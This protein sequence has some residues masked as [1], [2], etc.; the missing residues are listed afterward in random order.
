M[1]DRIEQLTRAIGDVNEVVAAIAIAATLEQDAALQRKMRSYAECPDGEALNLSLPVGSAALQLRPDGTIQPIRTHDVQA[2]VGFDDLVVRNLDLQISIELARPKI[3]ESVKRA[4]LPFI[5]P[6]RLPLREEYTRLNRW[7]ALIEKP[8]Y[9]FCAR[10]VGELDSWR[11]S[12]LA[13][14]NQGTLGA[15]TIIGKYSAL[16]H[17][18]AHLTLLCSSQEATP[19]LSDMAKSFTWKTWTPSFTL[20]RERTVWL[21]AAAARSAIAFGA[22]V[23]D[24]YVDVLGRATHVVQLFDALF[25][26]TAIGLAD[27]DVRDLVAREIAAKRRDSSAQPMTGA[28]FAE[29]AYLS[30]TVCLARSDTARLSHEELLD[31]LSWRPET[32]RGIA[33]RK[34]FRIDPTDIDDSGQMIGFRALPYLVKTGAPLHYPLHRHRPSSLLPTQNEIPELLSRAWGARNYE[35]RTVH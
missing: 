33:T 1:A 9:R 27:D 12:A 32:H 16:V 21:A 35:N 23:I 6:G 29:A 10:A 30:A 25:G 14:V 34:A 8:V 15:G 17:T 31:R 24:R 7:A 22:D 2:T 20:V 4:I 26:L 28:Q 13:D 18:V 5:L 11:A 3:T 19:W